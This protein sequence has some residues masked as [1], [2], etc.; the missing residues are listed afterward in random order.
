MCLINLLSCVNMECHLFMKPAALMK[1][2]ST[3]INEVEL[4]S[5]GEKAG[6]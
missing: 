2:M 3:E 6:M 4:M 5:N 1:D